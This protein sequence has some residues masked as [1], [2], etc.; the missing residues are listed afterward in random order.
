[1]RDSGCDVSYALRKD[2]SVPCSSSIAGGSGGLGGFKGVEYR[3]LG[4][5]GDFGV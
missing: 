2:G 1:M 3:E 5:L 4:V